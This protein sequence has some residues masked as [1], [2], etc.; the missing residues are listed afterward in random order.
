MNR[1]TIA[2]AGNPNV[3]KSTIFNSLTGLN[4]HTGNWPGKTVTT[5]SGTFTY[6]DTEF[7]VI[8]L[9]GAYSLCPDSPDEKAAADYIASGEADIILIIADASCLER[10]LLLVRDILCVSDNIV[11]CVNLMDEAEK[12]GIRVDIKRLSD[13]LGIPVTASSARSG[14]GIPELLQMLYDYTPCLSITSGLP[15]TSYIYSQCVN[16]RSSEPHITDRK[17][18]RIVT[19]KLLGFPIMIMM[20]IIIFW[21]TMSGANYPSAALSSLFAWTGEKIRYFLNCISLSPAIVSLI[22]DGI[23]T[24]L[25]WVISVMLPPMAIFFPLFTILED[26]GYLPR[27]AFNLDNAFKSCGAHGKQALTM[28]MGF[29][30][31]ACGVTGCRIIES[32]RERLIAVLTNCFVPCN[33]RFPALI[34][35][36]LIFLA[37]AFGAFSSVMAGVILTFFIIS[38]IIVTLLVSRILSKT[39]LKGIPSSFVLELPPYRRPQFRSII[40]RSLLDRTLFVLGRAVVVA[41]P[42]GAIIWLT[43]NIEAGDTSILNHMTAFLEPFGRAIGVDGVIITAFILGFPANEI[44]IPVMLMCYMS[45]GTLTDYTSLSQL[46]ETL[47][48]CGWTIQTAFCVLTLCMFHFPCGTTCLTIKKETGS[49]RWTA[50]AFIIPTVTGICLC[51]L[52]NTLF[53]II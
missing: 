20:L 10:N 40:I 23:Y 16:L 7:T 36:I 4:Q 13:I 43:A 39:L 8:D 44:V 35:L 48:G 12:K 27:I 18:D 53:H 30:C 6:K 49:L 15:D 34:T 50:L 47:S 21:L 17:I 5:A 45:T 19:S 38:G 33:G 24:T 51:F 2:L 3:G 9:P 52:L 11:L 26:S 1:K 41:A 25:T 31:N 22:M 29:G 37:P 14:E 28:C 46:H 42:A 32:P